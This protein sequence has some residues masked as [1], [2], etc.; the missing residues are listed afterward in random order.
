L[1]LE[2]H[3]INGD[4]L[5]NTFDEMASVRVG[6]ERRLRAFSVCDAQLIE[7]SVCEEH[8]LIGKSFFNK[9]SDMFCHHGVPFRVY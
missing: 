8:L 5:E 9:T 1:S 3:I 6:L 2:I 4:D 7:W